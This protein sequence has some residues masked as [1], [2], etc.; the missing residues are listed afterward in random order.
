MINNPLGAAKLTGKSGALSY[1]Y[2]TASERNSPFIVPGEE[3]SSF[4][5]T[6]LKSFS[7]ILRARYDV[8]SESFIGA[9]AT[10]RN[11]SSGHNY[12]GGLDW[13]VL[14]AGNY[15]F[16]GQFLYSNTREISDTSLFA[17]QR[18]FGNTS[19]TATF[20]GETYGGTALRAELAR[21]ARNLSFQLSYRDFSPTFQAQNGF[22]SGTDLRTF[23]IENDYT[24]Y[25]NSSLID[26]GRIFSEMGMHFNYAGALKERWIFLG[27][28]L[29]LK[30]QTNIFVGFLPLNE[31]MFRS[32]R[33]KELNRVI[34]NVNSRPFSILS[35]FLRTEVGRFIY[36]TDSPELGTG[37]NIA[38]EATIRPM[39]KIQIDLSYSRARL[40]SVVTGELFYDGY[41]ARTVAVYQF[42]SELYFRVI[43]QYNSFDK[44][45]HLYPLISY[46]LNPFT[47]FYAGSTHSLTNFGG[48]YGVQQTARQ[49]FLKIQYL[50]RS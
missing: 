39:D 11:F 22:V 5:S 42:S 9:L 2:L 3:G 31:E 44:S 10:A 32:V 50:W 46:K 47:I 15:Y 12:V 40:S 24:F 34:M 36:R 29:Q 7:N 8:G 48:P 4:V 16:R 19:Y 6:S 25:P 20:D 1:A 45:V 28:S 26:H 14:F 43:A 33:F 18:T 23:W 41:I 21:E 35:I 37:H 38:V 17:E 27:G 49:F 30:S 13:N